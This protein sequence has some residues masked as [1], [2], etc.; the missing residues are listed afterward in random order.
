MNEGH[1]GT[2]SI[3]NEKIYSEV[4]PPVIL[5]GI[6]KSGHRDILIGSVLAVQEDGTIDIVSAGSTYDIAGVSLENI[7][8]ADKQ[9]YIK[10]LAHGVVKGTSLTGLNGEKYTEISKL[11]SAGIYAE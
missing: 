3:L 10:Y 11:K 5:N 4:H 9:K 8:T 6:L 7:K 1:L 2:H